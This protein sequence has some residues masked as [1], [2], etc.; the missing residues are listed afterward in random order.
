MPLICSLSRRHRLKQKRRSQHQRKKR[1]EDTRFTQ[2]GNNIAQLNLPMLDEN[3]KFDLN[4]L[5]RLQ[6]FQTFESTGIEMLPLQWF[7]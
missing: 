2:G 3:T 7:I 6:N 5:Y 1:N 4:L